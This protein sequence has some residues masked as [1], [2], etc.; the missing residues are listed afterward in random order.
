MTKTE[1]LYTA[2][3]IIEHKSNGEGVL[4]IVIDKLDQK[5]ICYKHKD[6]TSSFVISGSSWRDV[7]EKLNQ[8]LISND[9]LKP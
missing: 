7:Y 2:P 3:D 8:L 4:K 5:G 1:F 6:N 9:Y